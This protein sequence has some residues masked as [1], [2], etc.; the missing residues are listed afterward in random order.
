MYLSCTKENF[1]SE[2]V[3]VLLLSST[4][5]ERWASNYIH[6]TQRAGKAR[7]SR[8]L[9]LGPS[10]LA[11][12]CLL[13]QYWWPYIQNAVLKERNFKARHNLLNCSNVTVWWDLLNCFEMNWPWES[14][15][16]CKALCRLG[17]RSELQFHPAQALCSYETPSKLSDLPNLS[18]LAYTMARVKRPPACV[19]VGRGLRRWDNSCQSVK[20]NPWHSVLSSVARIIRICIPDEILL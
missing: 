20:L 19:Y 8:P 3:G 6:S 4:V 1:G 2:S 11:S 12:Q 5:E 10:A 18:C 14:I 13:I 15:V 9:L 16:G 17:L 7:I